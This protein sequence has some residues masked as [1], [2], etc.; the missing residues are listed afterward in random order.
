MVLPEGPDLIVFSEARSAENSFI[1]AFTAITFAEVV[2]DVF[3][4]EEG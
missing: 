1:L 3:A 2:P 4:A